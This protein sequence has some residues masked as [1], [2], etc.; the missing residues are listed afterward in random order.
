MD[1]YSAAKEIYAK[2]GVDTDAA[3]LK[4]KK[5]P[6]SLHCWQGDDVGG[7]E[8]TNSILGGGGIATTGNYPGK[9][10]NIDQLKS[11]LEMAFSLI[12][13]RHKVNLHASYLDNGGTFVDR[14][15]IETKH[16]ETWVDF[17]K[18]NNVGLDFNPTYYSHPKSNDG[19]TL[20]HPDKA[21][22]EFWIE[23]GKRV[24]KIAEY[25]GKQL[26]KR[27]V[28]NH[29]MPDGYKDTPV[30]R[31][32]PR[33]RMKESLDEVFKEKID[34][35]YNV[36]A[37]ESK[38]FGLGSESYVVGSHEFFMGYAV[39]NKDLLLCMDVG[40]FHPTETVSNKISSM[41]IFCDEL[42]LHVSRP[43]RWDSDHVVIFDD[44]L[45]AIAH[46]IIACNCLDRVNI[47]LDYFDAS[48]NRIAAWVIGVRATQKALLSALLEPI[49]MMKKLELE[50][51]YTSRLA[52]QEEQKAMP[53]G[54]VWNQFCEICNVPSG[55]DW[56]KD[57]KKYEKD[58]LSLR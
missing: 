21:I 49:D 5:I 47:A 39:T 27:C 52:L 51:D 19:L 23:H 31:L 1:N 9:A 15:A 32:V 38:L 13:E 22:R 56:I 3:L 17:A 30:D 24:R 42:L 34:K 43:V 4:L 6:I 10:K 16:F 45:Q 37:V 14:D 36:D 58:V 44:E 48:I 55:A 18:K 29:W 35:K 2:I 53:M 41:S 7:Y 11:D 46:E 26:G 40:H 28:T 50:G 57:I 8:T 20:A 25:F 33:L 54:L 12:P